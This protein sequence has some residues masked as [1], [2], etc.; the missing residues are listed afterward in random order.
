MAAKLR[1][2][3]TVLCALAMA[4]LVGGCNNATMSS[5][6]AQIN[7]MVIRP[8]SLGVSTS[9]RMDPRRFEA[10]SFELANTR[11]D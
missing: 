3:P 2:K 9:V 7:A 4:L 1:A 11:R 5:D 6:R 8:T 10:A